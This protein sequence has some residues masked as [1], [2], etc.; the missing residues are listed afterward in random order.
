M[1]TTPTIPT[2]APAKKVPILEM[3]KLWQ[4]FLIVSGLILIC[5]GILGLIYGKETIIMMT[6]T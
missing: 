3:G 6:E 2:V 1:N 5:L 4:I